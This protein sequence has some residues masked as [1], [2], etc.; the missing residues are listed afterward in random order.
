VKQ[1]YKVIDVARCHDCNNCFMADRDEFVGNDWPG[2]TA[3]Q[4]RHGHRWV[5]ILR[6]ERGVYARIDV[7]FLPVPCQHCENAP[8]MEVGKGLVVRRPDGI[9]MI[10]MEKAKGNKAL[11]DSCPYGAIWWNEE[12]NIAQKCIFCAHLLDDPTWKPHT[13]RCV[14]SCP[15]EAMAT[16]FVEPEEMEKMIAAEDLEAY[17]PEL[18]TKPRTLYKNLYKFTKNFITAGVLVDGDCFEGAT[19]TLHSKEGGIACNLS[20]AGVANCVDTSALATRTTNFFGEFKFDGLENGEYSLE[21]DA[22]GRKTSMVVTVKDA[23]ENLGFIE[24]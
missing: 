18:G 13:T 20:G 3:A 22:G 1:W 2:Y 5:D 10:D 9:V 19:V 11:V 15:T 23:S 16:Y 12:A 4:P 6:R 21:V 7:A 14:H 17:R 8:C 24:L